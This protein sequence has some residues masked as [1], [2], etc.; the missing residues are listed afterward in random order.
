M[1]GCNKGFSGKGSKRSVELRGK[2]EAENGL[3][4]Q[5]RAIVRKKKKT[6]CNNTQ[7][8]VTTRKL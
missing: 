3:N 8:S 1:L 6:L 5:L 7:K 2:K 4:K